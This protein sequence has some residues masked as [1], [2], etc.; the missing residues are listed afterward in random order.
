M[1]ILFL[2]IAGRVRV[3]GAVKLLC[4]RL[5]Y[6]F[7]GYFMFCGKSKIAGALF[8]FT[9]FG[10]C[11]LRGGCRLGVPYR[12]GTGAGRRLFRPLRRAGR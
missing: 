11:G 6:L 10:C 5:Y 3:R 1:I 4:I 9:G 12:Q 2:V 8:Y 7:S